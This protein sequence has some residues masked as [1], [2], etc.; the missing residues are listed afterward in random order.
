MYLHP[1][2]KNKIKIQEI[3]QIF[4]IILPNLKFKIRLCQN[5]F[6]INKGL[7]LSILI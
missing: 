5:K 3:L 4:I 1:T 7:K 2:L 6:N